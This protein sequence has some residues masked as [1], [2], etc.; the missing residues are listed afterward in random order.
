MTKIVTKSSD[1]CV[2]VESYVFFCSNICND[3]VI[4]LM[5]A[6]QYRLM[7]CPVEHELYSECFFFNGIIY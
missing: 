1:L 3:L 2:T 6:T 5:P 4:K 7:L